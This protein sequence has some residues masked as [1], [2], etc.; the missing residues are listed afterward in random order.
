MSRN[1]NPT[2]LMK[3]ASVALRATGKACRG[4]S[5]GTS[6]NLPYMKRQVSQAVYVLINK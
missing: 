1:S 2:E 4:I 3:A 5:A 6:Q